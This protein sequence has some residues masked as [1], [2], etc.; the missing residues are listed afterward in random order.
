MSR[1]NPGVDVEGGGFGERRQRSTVGEGGS[2]PFGCPESELG[3]ISPETL[4]P[5][6]PRH[7]PSL[8]AIDGV[9]HFLGAAVGGE[10]DRYRV[11][12][13][14]GQLPSRPKLVGQSCCQSQ[15]GSLVFS[16]LQAHQ[17]DSGDQDHETQ[18]DSDFDERKAA[19]CAPIHSH[20]LTQSL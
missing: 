1:R 17:G 7:V 19:S 8:Q 18:D 9:G 5:G 4:G 3:V 2:A 16:G 12:V 11:A 6:H 13:T 20:S 10:A 14:D 15:T